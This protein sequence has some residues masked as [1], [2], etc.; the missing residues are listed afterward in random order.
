MDPATAP[1][2]AQAWCGEALARLPHTRF[3]YGPP[4]DA[5]A[6]APPPSIKRG[7]VTFG[8]F[9]NIAKLGPDVAGACGR[10]CWPRFRARGWC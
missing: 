5:P 9:N 4:R 3:C 2:G 1:Q 6:P 7:R 8:S 10:R